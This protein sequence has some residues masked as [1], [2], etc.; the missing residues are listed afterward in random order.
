MVSHHSFCVADLFNKHDQAVVAA[1]QKSVCELRYHRSCACPKN[2]NLIEKKVSERIL[3]LSK[4]NGFSP[5][6]LRHRSVLR[7]A[8][9]QWRWQGKSQSVG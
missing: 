3:K 8:I 1:G 2:S 5:I 4:H 6:F 7:N 9:E